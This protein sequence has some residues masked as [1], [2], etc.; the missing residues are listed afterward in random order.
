MK[1]NRIIRAEQRARLALEQ[2]EQELT[3]RGV[4]PLPLFPADT[5]GAGRLLLT[6]L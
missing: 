3:S 2:I 6:G 5:V 4:S 1:S